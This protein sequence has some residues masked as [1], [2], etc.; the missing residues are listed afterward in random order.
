[1]HSKKG[2]REIFD[3]IK[4]KQLDKLYLF[5]GQENYVKEQALNQ[6]VQ[7]LVPSELKHLNYQALD[8]ATVSADDIINACETLPFMSDRR[9]V[10]VKDLSPLLQGGRTTL[11]EDKL[12][13][14]LPRIPDTTCLVFYCEGQINRRKALFTT[15][16]QIGIVIEFE[17][18]KPEEI[19]TWVRSVLK[20]HGK[21]MDL[22]A[23]QHYI[24]IAGNRLEDIYN[25]LL[26]LIAYTG[27][28]DTIT[29]DDI[30]KVVA[31]AAE[32]TVFQL[33]EAIGTMKVDQALTFLDKLLSE[34]ENVFSLLAMIARQVRIIFQ[35]KGYTQKGLSGKEIA[36]KLGIHPYVAKKCLEQ[37]RYFTLE[38]LRMGLDECLKADYNIKS[39]KMQ[40]RLGIEMLIINMCKN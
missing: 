37:S 2:Y 24:N 36:Q 16:S 17:L 7:M 12:K 39:G 22:A 1:M 15:V 19:S 4:N 10:V 30:N 28:K 18:L 40:Q 14:Y 21:H 25:D 31:P 27:D 35:C 5:H 26:K 34:G 3:D 13:N 9:L 32:Y 29:S 8:G 23:L 33:V 38:Q 20:R 11:D 6:L